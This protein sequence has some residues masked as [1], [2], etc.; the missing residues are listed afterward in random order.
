MSGSSVAGFTVLRCLVPVS[1]YLA[2]LERFFS[3][4]GGLPFPMPRHVL[5][6]D[7]R[8]VHKSIFPEYLI[9]LGVGHL[10]WI[11]TIYAQRSKN[12]ASFGILMWTHPFQIVFRPIHDVTVLV[13]ALVH[14]AVYHR[15]RT[16]EDRT[17]ED[18]TIYQPIITHLRIIATSNAVVAMSSGCAAGKTEVLKHLFQPATLGER[19]EQTATGDE[20]PAFGATTLYRHV[21]R[22]EIQPPTVSRVRYE[23][24]WISSTRCVLYNFN[25]FFTHNI[26]FWRYLERLDIRCLVPKSDAKF[27]QKKDFLV[28]RSP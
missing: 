23:Q 9:Q 5:L 15:S 1:S 28:K 6:H 7:L 24:L 14:N 18:V 10:S 12:C 11:T 17:D 22:V 20:Q 21:A 27:A 26:A 8:S 19:E 4:A 16:M 3:R 25:F 2:T 13:V